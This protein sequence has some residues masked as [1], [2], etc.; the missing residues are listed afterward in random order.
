MHNAADSLMAAITKYD[1]DFV[2]MSFGESNRSL[3]EDWLD[4]CSNK[5]GVPNEGFFS[6]LQKIYFEHFYQR[7]FAA[8]EVVFL[9]AAPYSTRTLRKSNE[10]E[11]YSD[12]QDVKNRLMVSGFSVK[13]SELP[14]R[15]SNAMN[16]LSESFS[17]PWDCVDFYINFGVSSMRPYDEGPYP[18]LTT[19]NGVGASSIGT[20]PSTSIATPIGL[21]YII[22]LKKS[23]IVSGRGVEFTRNFKS[24]LQGKLTDPSRFRHFEIYRLGRL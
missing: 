16:L 14:I 3:K 24:Y 21:S 6:K 9:Q 17:G 18:V 4:F 20:R 7:L 15:G 11:F 12:C 19:M 8:K 13:D 5:K 10:S 23:G 2:N 1:I 22:Y